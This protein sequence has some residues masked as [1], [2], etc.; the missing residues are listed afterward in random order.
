MAAR[1]EGAA[2][3]GDAGWQEYEAV[4]FVSLSCAQ[5]LARKRPCGC[6]VILI[7]RGLDHRE[8]EK[9]ADQCFSD[10]PQPC[11]AEFSDL[12]FAILSPK[13]VG[14]LSS[15]RHNDDYNRFAEVAVF[16]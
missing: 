10:R 3:D 8:Q 6:R 12:N 1:G 14:P 16:R 7:R 2:A 13:T 4:E 9:G 15:L 5:R 11:T